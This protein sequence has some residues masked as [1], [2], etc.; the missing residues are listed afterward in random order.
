MTS[1]LSNEP[2]TW[3]K[4]QGCPP[5]ICWSLTQRLFYIAHFSLSFCPYASNPGRAEMRDSLTAI[6]YPGGSW[7][8]DGRR[9]DSDPMQDCQG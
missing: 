5:L 1:E 4:G 7:P 8:L 3:R 9:P 6:A 2:W